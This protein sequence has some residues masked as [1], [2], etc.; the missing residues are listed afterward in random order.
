MKRWDLERRINRIAKAHRLEAVW[1]EGGNHTKVKV[2]KA[3]TSVPR[4]REIN[5][6]TANGII[7]YIERHMT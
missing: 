3:E 6:L 2:G 4:H 1:S 5:E 7:H